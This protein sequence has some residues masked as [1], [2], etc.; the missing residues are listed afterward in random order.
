[1]NDNLNKEYLSYFIEDAVTKKNCFIM[2]IIIAT[3]IILILPSFPL[4]FDVYLP[5]SLLLKKH[6]PSFLRIGDILFCDVKTSMMNYAKELNYLPLYFFPGYSNDHCMMYIGN[7]KFIESCPYYFQSD[8]NQYTGVVITPYE[9][10]FLWATNITFGTVNTSQQI[11]NGAVEWAKHQLG[12][13]YGKEGF[14]C[15]ELIWQAY[16]SRHL[17]LNYTYLSY[18]Y[19]YNAFYPQELRIANQ[20]ILYD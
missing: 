13:P 18:H 12:S 9:L 2:F 17:T 7:N 15:G 3:S 10:I 14:Y 4:T 6:V 1:M 5:Q 11:R 20:V 8:T 19:S 16:H